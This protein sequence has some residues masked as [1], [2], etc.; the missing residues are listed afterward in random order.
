MAIVTRVMAGDG[1]PVRGYV[2]FEVDYDDVNL[3]LTALRCINNSTEACWGKVLKNSN[4]RTYERTFAANTT[5]T[6]TI[7]TGAA[8]RLTITITPNGKIDGVDYFFMWPA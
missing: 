4:G 8:G 7:P 3:R 6:L 5:T 2:R 1:D